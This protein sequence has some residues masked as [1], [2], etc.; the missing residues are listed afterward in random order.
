MRRPLVVLA[1]IAVLLAAGIAAVVILRL[2]Q[3]GNIRGSSTEEFTLPT[4]TAKP[5]APP[6]H[7]SWPQYGFDATRA[8]CVR[9][10]RNPPSREVWRYYA[11]TL[12]EFP[13]AIAFG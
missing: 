2:H 11:G 13:P 12:V 8:R 9:L 1:V 6:L 4:T 5:T 10:D 7:I 3:P